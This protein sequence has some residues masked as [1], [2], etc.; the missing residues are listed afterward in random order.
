VKPLLIWV[1]VVAVLFGGLGVLSSSLNETKRTFVLVDSSFEMTAVWADVRGAVA[2]IG[3]RED[4]EFALATEKELVHSWAD[5]LDVGGISPYA[6]CG[7]GDVAY[8]EIDQADELVL[9]TT[10]GSCD[11]SLFEGWE[12][13]L[14]EP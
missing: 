10:V 2:D 9:V 5:R 13:I 7:F 11:R 14:L 4:H 6:P 3:S 1:T 8:A 12:I